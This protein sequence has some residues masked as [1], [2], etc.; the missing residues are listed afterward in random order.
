MSFFLGTKSGNVKVGLANKL[1]L[2]F[3]LMLLRPPDIMAAPPS[4]RPVACVIG[5]IRQQAASW[6]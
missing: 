1:K 5:P 4:A 6:V 2:Y 3:H